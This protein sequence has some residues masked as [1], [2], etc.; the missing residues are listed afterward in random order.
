MTQAKK[1]TVSLGD[2]LK[3]TNVPIYSGKAKEK[4]GYLE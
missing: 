1:I 4:W 3:E 2:E